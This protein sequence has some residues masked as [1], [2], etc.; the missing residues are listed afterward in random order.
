VLVKKLPAVEAL[1]QARH[2]AVDK[3]GTI[4]KNELVI[5]EVIAAGGATYPISGIGYD[6]EPMIPNPSSELLLAARVAALC[7]NSRI[8]RDAHGG[9]RLVGDPTEGAMEVFAAKAGFPKEKVFA[10]Y[11]P[12]QDWPFDYQKKFHLALYEKASVPFLAI[13]GAPEIILKLSA[14]VISG[15]STAPL[16]ADLKKALEA[17]FYELSEHGLRVIAYAFKNNAPRGA[18]PDNLPPLTLGGFFAMRDAL[19]EGIK[20][21][22]L[23]AEEAGIRVFMITG[24][25]AITAKTIAAQA[26]IYREGDGVLTGAEIEAL[27]ESEFARRLPGTTVFARVTPE[28]KLKII[29]GYRKQGEIIAM[30]G[31]GVNDAPS[32]VAADLGIA[33]GKIGTEVAKE[34]SDLVLLDDNFGDV[35]NAVEEGRNMRQGIRRTITYLFSSNLGEILLITFALVARFPL[36]LLAAQLIWMNVVTDTFFDISLSLEPKD[37]TLMR[38][39]AQIPKKLF[40]SFMAK[41]LLLIAPVIALG[42]FLL[43]QAQL[44]DITRAR[45]I[46]LTSL[47]VFQWFNAMNCRSEDKS[48]FRMNPV[49]N[50]FL[51]GTMIWVIT[52]H[53]FALYNPFMNKILQISPLALRDVA[54]IAAIA[55]SIVAVEELRKWRYRLKIQNAVE[56]L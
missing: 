56:R 16:R 41:R 34:A 38:R 30:T 14:T 29:Q 53:S 44:E 25:H 6:P 51:A 15:A 9:Y 46:A 8:S 23:S 35:L 26:G 27:P 17:R 42:S 31:D 24:D 54:V 55:L 28:H 12:I 4:T 13:T 40:D 21:Q 52:L 33:M 37:K 18:N 19:R 22:V 3:T 45:T 48:I 36:P 20:E 10:E 32:L 49:G 5:Q 50:K 39:G 1:G 11:R 47:V 2:I 7:S 43:F